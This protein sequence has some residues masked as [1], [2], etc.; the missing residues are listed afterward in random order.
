MSFNHELLVVWILKEQRSK[1]P[2]AQL[3]IARHT[4]TL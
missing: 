4:G 1:F 3:L 2:P